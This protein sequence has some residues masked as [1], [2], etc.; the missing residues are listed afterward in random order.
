MQVEHTPASTTNPD[1]AHTHL[2]RALKNRSH[3]EVRGVRST[4]PGREQADELQMEDRDS[5][6]LDV[7]ERTK[8][9]YESRVKLIQDKQA[10]QRR[11]ATAMIPREEEEE[12][13]PLVDTAV[14]EH[15]LGE[16]GPVERD[17]L[18]APDSNLLGT[19]MHSISALLS[20][21]CGRG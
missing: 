13:S 7:R 8:R 21:L 14:T 11:E 10:A 5:E 15:I 2:R 9:A 6:G 17:A 18:T 4:T 12:Q 1:E 20:L 19:P 16:R 3:S